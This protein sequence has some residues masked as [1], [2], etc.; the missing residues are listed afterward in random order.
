MGAKP[1]GRAGTTAAKRIDEGTL[2][3]SSTAA[4][5]V[6]WAQRVRMS[7]CRAFH[8]DVSIVVS[9]VR[10]AAGQENPMVSS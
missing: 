4:L 2:C 8:P 1:S 3:A 10:D 6:R 7:L 5:L 9:P